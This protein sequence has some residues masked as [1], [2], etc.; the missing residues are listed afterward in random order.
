MSIVI[1]AN[2]ALAFASHG[3]KNLIPQ[4]PAVH[5]R[6]SMSQG[7]P[8]ET[9][10]SRNEDGVPP[11]G[12]DMNGILH[13][14]SS[15]Q[16]FL[17]TGGMYRFD[18]DYAALIRGYAMGAVLQLDDGLS[19]VISTQSAN[20]GNPNLTMTGW[21]PYAGKLLTDQIAALGGGLA[22]IVDVIYPVGIIIEFKHSI[23]PED[24]FPG[25]TWVLYG[26]GQTTVGYST[27][28][29]DPAWTKSIDAV[30]G[31]Y[32]CELTTENLPN[33]A[34]GQ[35]IS[36]LGGQVKLHVD[37]QTAGE[38]SGYATSTDYLAEF[39]DKQLVSTDP[40]GSAEAFSIVQPSIVVA[41]WCRI[42]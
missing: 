15:H 6:A 37:P 33:V 26:Q 25:T 18:A 4:D 27:V 30:Q 1:P 9:M 22:G 7:F 17:N 40:I 41:R 32:E 28:T 19:A 16:V 11:R 29:D 3:L 35:K 34:L 12:R 42:A 36:A 20:S 13:Q 39:T 10:R 21:A 14:L 8:E 31:G 38:F 5:G 2:N 23:H 24:L